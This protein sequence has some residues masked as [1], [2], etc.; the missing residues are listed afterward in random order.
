[1]RSSRSSACFLRPQILQATN[2]SAPRTIAPPT[3]TTTP[4]TVFLVSGVMPEGWLLPLLAR[5]GVVVLVVWVVRVVA[6]PLPSTVVI[7]RVIVS[8]ISDVEESLGGWLEPVGGGVEL[9]VEGADV[10][11]VEDEVLEGEVWD[12]VE[13]VLDEELVGGGVEL[14]E[15]G[16][17]ELLPD[18]RLWIIAPLGTGSRT[19]ASTAEKA[20]NPSTTKLNNFVECI[21][22]LLWNNLW[23]IDVTAPFAR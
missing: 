20:E 15:V 11:D 18:C 16:L 14:D 7:I 8:T 13:L 22:T 17:L 9:V 12:V 5:P 3:P 10:R 2:A 23:A 19:L 6:T 4:M 21:V 1:M